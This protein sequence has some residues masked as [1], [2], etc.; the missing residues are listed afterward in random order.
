MAFPP[1]P[2]SIEEKDSN[3]DPVFTYIHPLASALFDAETGMFFDSVND[4]GTNEYKK[5]YAQALIRCLGLK[6][7]YVPPEILS[8]PYYKMGYE[9]GI[10]DY[11][12]Y[13]ELNGSSIT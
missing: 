6:E 11:M 3:P 13:E 8:D 10:Y 2:L 1:D 4:D 12:T 7:P 5:G 9:D